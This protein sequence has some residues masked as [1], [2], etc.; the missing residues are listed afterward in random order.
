[1]KTFIAL[2]SLN[3]FFI[4]QAMQR[5]AQPTELSA[6]ARLETQPAAESSHSASQHPSIYIAQLSSKIYIENLT[7]DTIFVHA[8][9][10]G[11]ER[12]I[13]DIKH[14]VAKDQ[15]YFIGKFETLQSLTI[16]PYGEI[17]EKMEV[18]KLTFG[19]MQTKNLVDYI[20]CELNK[21]FS[22]DPIIPSFTIT[23]KL[24]YGL[25]GYVLPYQFGVEKGHREDYPPRIWDVFPHVRKIIDQYPMEDRLDEDNEADAQRK[26]DNNR[27]NNAE[28]IRRIR[29]HYFLGVEK[30]AERGQ[31]E[32]EYGN[33]CKK[34]QPRVLGNNPERENLARRVLEF[35]NAA[36]ECLIHR[37]E[38]QIKL[39]T[40]IMHELA[41]P[42]AFGRIKHTFS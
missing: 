42:T 40:L 5:E 1:M 29:P 18:S 31:I 4:V 35:V 22:Q 27:R 8:K 20:K 33:L 32:R 7:S 15:S 14:T 39:N 23:V 12:D 16:V 24:Q 25:L 34:W 11:I 19:Y 41:A 10:E 2:A 9:N 36:Y 30:G 13:K 17:K 3:F 26:S 37:D 6:Q 28:I 38:F 21:F